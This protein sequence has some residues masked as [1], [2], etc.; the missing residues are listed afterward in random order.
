MH[1][2]SHIAFVLHSKVGRTQGMAQPRRFSLSLTDA[3]LDALRTAADTL[4]NIPSAEAT[5]RLFGRLSALDALYG[6]RIYRDA[7][8]HDAERSVVKARKMDVLAAR[9]KRRS[10]RCKGG[11]FVTHAYSC[12]LPGNRAAARNVPLTVNRPYISKVAPTGL[13]WRPRL[14]LVRPRAV[15]STPGHT[16]HTGGVGLTRLNRGEEATFWWPRCAAGVVPCLLPKASFPCRRRCAILGPPPVLE[17]T[18]WRF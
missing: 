2:P 17:C 9:K 13:S 10:G 3:Q 8:K 15:P 5:E 16:L 12:E 6:R 14:S 4:L 11:G 18:L 1:G 7:V